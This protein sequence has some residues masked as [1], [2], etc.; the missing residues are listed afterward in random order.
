MHSRRHIGV[1]PRTPRPARRQ[2]RAL[3]DK[4]I[5]RPRCIR[6]FRQSSIYAIT[7]RRRGKAANR[8]S[9]HPPGPPETATNNTTEDQHTGL[10]PEVLSP[11]HNTSPAQ[12]SNPS[13]TAPYTVL[14]HYLRKEGT[15]HTSGSRS[16]T[17]AWGRTPGSR[18]E[19]GAYN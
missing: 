13:C 19:P 2:S 7:V 18:P 6:R 14:R 5:T 3:A 1:G 9:I 8:P 15:R 16:R 12:L 11:R 10:S 17:T 4:L